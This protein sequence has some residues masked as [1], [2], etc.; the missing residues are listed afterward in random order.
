MP[1]TVRTLRSALRGTHRVSG[2]RNASGGRRSGDALL[3]VSSGDFLHTLGGR[4]KEVRLIQASDNDQAPPVVVIN[5]TL[6]RLYFPVS[7]EVV[8]TESNPTITE[9]RR[10]NRAG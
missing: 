8:S 3:R 9:S 6:A 4:L 1:H 2:S 5:E 7:T 10:R